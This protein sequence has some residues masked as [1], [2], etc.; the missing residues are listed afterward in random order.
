MSFTKKKRLLYLVLWMAVLSLIYWGLGNTSLAMPTVFSFG[1]LCFLLSVLYV[2]VGGGIRPI[3]EEDRR[4]EE[5]VHQKYLK[6]KGVLHPVKRRDKYRRF[7]VKTEEEPK[8]EDAPLPPRPNPLK[9]PEEKRVL[10]SQ[11]LLVLVIP[12]YL[13]FFIDWLIVT[14]F[15]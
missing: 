1:V 2:L 3:L 9:I 13:I 12:F 5:K 6:D 11:L 10:F 4:R 7:R 15:F 8:K 14:I